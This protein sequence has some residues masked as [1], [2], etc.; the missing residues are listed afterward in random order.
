MELVSK[1]LLKAI[2]AEAE[3]NGFFPPTDSEERLSF[4][5][6]MFDRI[7]EKLIPVELFKIVSSF[8]LSCY[9]R[10]GKG[11]NGI[12]QEIMERLNIA[13]N[14]NIPLPLIDFFKHPASI[15][16]FILNDNDI[17]KKTGCG[18][19]FYSRYR[20]LNK[21]REETE[22]TEA[23]IKWD[24]TYQKKKDGEFSFSIHIF[25]D[26]KTFFSFLDEYDRGFAS[27][28]KYNKKQS[29]KS[30]C[31]VFEMNTLKSSK[32]KVKYLRSFAQWLEEREEV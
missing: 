20:D 24:Y 1:T 29:I 30:G 21:V 5:N 17:E 12:K 14:A 32:K 16:D 11:Y 10:E 25:T 31:N 18:N 3:E 23:F 19:W 2:K 6:L 28:F 26:W 8:S 22:E 7:E 9:D 27:F 15:A 4:R 13:N